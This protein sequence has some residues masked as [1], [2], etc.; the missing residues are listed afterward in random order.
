[1]AIIAWPGRAARLDGARTPWDGGGPIAVITA[2]GIQR[3]GGEPSGRA[4][5]PLSPAPTAILAL[6]DPL[7][8]EVLDAAANLGVWVPRELSII[9]VDDTPTSA[10]LGLASA[11]VPFRPIGEQA[12]ILLT[13][14]LAGGAQP[15]PQPLPTQLVVRSTSGPSPS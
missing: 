1:M 10:G 6:S 12:G 4:P 9:E 11:S 8:F 3:I 5:L 15:T 14:M 7:T 2:P 13:A